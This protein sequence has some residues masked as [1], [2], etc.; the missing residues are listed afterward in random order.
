[1]FYPLTQITVQE[2]YLFAIRLHLYQC[3]TLYDVKFRLQIKNTYFTLERL[4]S[5][6]YAQTKLSDSG[7]KTESY[8]ITTNLLFL[9][10][11]FIIVIKVFVYAHLYIRCI[12]L[13]ITLIE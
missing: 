7:S 1:M 5:S 12:S 8:R 3:G 6:F 4:S 11:F 13:N 9:S 10:I 2:K